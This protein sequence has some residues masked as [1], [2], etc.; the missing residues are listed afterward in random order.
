[1]SVKANK[2]VIVGSSPFLGPSDLLDAPLILAI[3]F[4]KNKSFEKQYI[5]EGRFWW[6]EMHGQTYDVAKAYQSILVKAL[7]NGIEIN[8]FSFSRATDFLDSIR[9]RSTIGVLHEGHAATDSKVKERVALMFPGNK[10]LD[11]NILNEYK[12]S[13]HYASESSTIQTGK[14]L[15]FIFTSGCRAGYCRDY[16]KPVI[17]LSKTRWIASFEDLVLRDINGKTT[18]DYFKIINKLNT[19]IDYLI[20]QKNFTQNPIKK[21]IKEIFYK[22]NLILKN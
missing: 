8:V 21:K 14:E 7:K 17:D 1:M 19:H 9:D 20:E 6:Q 4:I 12:L 5:K 18:E 11:N 10:I 13:P 2:I 15:S 16:Y 3:M 22:K